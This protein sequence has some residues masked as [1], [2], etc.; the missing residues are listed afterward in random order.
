MI[1]KEVEVEKEWA[2]LKRKLPF[3]QEVCAS[4]KDLGIDIRF[5]VNI[6]CELDRLAEEATRKKL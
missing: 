1:N 2:Y 5:R 3:E 4:N 6:K